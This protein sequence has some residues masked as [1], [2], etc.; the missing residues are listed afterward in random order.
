MKITY[1]NEVANLCD[2]LGAYSDD[3]LRGMGYD[4]RIGSDFLRPGI[5][6]GG[7]CFEKDVKSIRHIATQL[8]PAASSSRRPCGSTSPADARHRR[9]SNEIGSLDGATSPCGA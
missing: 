8:E 3:V 9:L 4:P 7:P 5:G 2:A 1:A 6:F